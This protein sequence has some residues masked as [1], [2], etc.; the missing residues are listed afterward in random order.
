MSELVVYL[1]GERAGRLVLKENGNLQFRYDGG[2]SGP[3]IS[4]ALP[5]QK[6][7]HPH[8]ICR[9]VFG[10]LLLEG[11][12]RKAIARNF[13]ISVGNDYALLEE[14][15]GDCAGALTL[16]PPGSSL[17]GEPLLRELSAEDLD[18]TI[19][20]LPARPLAADPE[21][22]TRLS[23]AGA[24]PKLPV[25]VEGETVSLPLNAAAATTHIVKPEPSAF[26]GL[27][28]NELFCM[29][30]ARRIELPTA[31]VARR[32]TRSGVPYLIVERYDRDLTVDPIRRLHQEDFCQAL[33]RPSDRKY[34][35]EGGPSVEQAVSLLRR[36][37]AVP[38]RD[39][40]TFWK[41]LVF[42]WLIGNC[43]AH[44][45]NYSLLYDAGTKATLAPLYDL[46]STTSYED[47]ETK[48][49]MSIDGARELLDVDDA[50]WRELA[51][52]TNFSQR[53]RL[54]T[55]IELAE[56]VAV[57]S[58]ALAMNHAHDN[59]TVK[60]ILDG[61]LERSE[62]LAQEASRPRVAVAGGHA[63]LPESG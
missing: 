49:A 23:L 42:N 29:E 24:Q 50:A 20:E 43:D 40:P 60:A 8:A 14:L 4:Q 3:P 58:R 6:D 34:Q 31:S 15:G 7:A 12:G 52:Q 1:G 13:G 56:R 51:E 37:S 17:P 2:Y 41:A 54:Q 10:G 63:G 61:I 5:L 36:A 39:L 18:E 57:E 25:I 59:E 55:Q 26:P 44:G 21:A 19:R 53:F 32:E 47:L 30:L 62:R 46:V 35:V 38:A 45:K 33:G 22:G 28:D 48:L 27:V 16:V 11:E 9:A